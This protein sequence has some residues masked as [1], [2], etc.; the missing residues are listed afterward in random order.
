MNEVEILEY[1]KGLENRDISPKEENTFTNNLKEIK[2]NFVKD[3]NQQKAKKIWCYEQIYNVQNIY[4]S[5]FELMKKNKFYEAWQNFEQI[6]IKLSFLYPHFKEKNNE[7]YLKLILEYTRK[8]QSL[9]PYKFFISTEEIIKEKECSICGKKI[10]LRNH[11]GHI[12]GEIYDGEMC[13][14]RIT[15]VDFIGVS[16]VN[17]PDR[18]YA[19]AFPSTSEGADSFDYKL[20]KYLINLLESPFEKW[21]YKWSK[22]RHPHS[23]F[24]DITPNDNCPCES[25]KKYVD[26]CL[27]EKGVLRPHCQFYFY[28]EKKEKMDFEYCY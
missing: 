15:K 23:F 3:N 24:K 4:L 1:L 16:L 20:L 19:V 11:C 13:L 12:P 6:E 9:Y 8:F 14:R 21:N 27:N 26:C 22:R 5:A 2:Q 7:F 17:S 25:G 10:S 18:K 28:K